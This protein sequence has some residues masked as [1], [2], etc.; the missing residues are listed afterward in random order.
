MV[1]KQ[2]GQPS[3]PWSSHL[4]KHQNVVIRLTLPTIPDHFRLFS[5]T[6][7]RTSRSPCGRFLSACGP[8]PLVCC[9]TTASS[10]STNWTVLRR[11]CLGRY[12]ETGPWTRSRSRELIWARSWRLSVMFRSGRRSRSWLV[13]MVCTARTRGANEHWRVLRKPFRG[14]PSTE[15]THQTLVSSFEIDYVS[16]SINK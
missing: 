14:R 13:N 5:I 8:A 7:S 9:G 2:C 4:S 16:V 10:V 3:D 6:R 1:L 12:S 11:G 15:W